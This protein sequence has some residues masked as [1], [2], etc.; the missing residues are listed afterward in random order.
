MHN[1]MVVSLS[2]DIIET[3]VGFSMIGSV[4]IRPFSFLF[5][6]L[7][8]LACFYKS[9]RKDVREIS[10]REDKVRINIHKPKIESVLYFIIATC[11]YY[12]VDM[13]IDY[14]N[15]EALILYNFE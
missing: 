5:F 6:F 15:R 9:I 13:D 12:I 14:I 7:F 4:C 1:R 11:L 10:A 8:L 2:I 3:L